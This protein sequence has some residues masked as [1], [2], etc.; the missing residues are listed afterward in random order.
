M[1]SEPTVFFTHTALDLESAKTIRLIEVVPS[2]DGGHT[3][4]CKLT[5]ATT[6]SRYVCL[7]YVWHRRGYMS[8]SHQWFTF[9][10][11]K[12]LVGFPTECLSATL[13]EPVE[14]ES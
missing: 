10:S 12:Q 7:S 4:E 6:D 8:Y 2:R 5:H 11:A 14:L 13:S 1:M 9:Q 3:V